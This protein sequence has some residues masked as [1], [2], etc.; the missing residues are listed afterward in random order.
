M[1]SISEVEKAEKNQRVRLLFDLKVKKAAVVWYDE[2]GR[3]IKIIPFQ[4][5]TAYEYI[6]FN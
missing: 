1:L 6:N 4:I 5:E 3:I 2:K